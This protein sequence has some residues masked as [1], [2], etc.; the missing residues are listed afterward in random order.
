MSVKVNAKLPVKA[1]PR[2]AIDLSLES[3][4][5]LEILDNNIVIDQNINAIVNA[6]ANPLIKFNVKPI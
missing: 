4:K 6:L 3:D 2:I 5:L 1:A